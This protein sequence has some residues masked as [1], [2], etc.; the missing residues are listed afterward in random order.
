MADQG[1]G[2]SKLRL[3]GA[4]VLLVE[5]ATI[6]AMWAQST[7]EAAGAVV[8]GPATRVSQALQLATT[9]RFDLGLLDID[10]NGELVWPV[11]DALMQ[12]GIPFV[13]TT[14]YEGA[15]SIPERLSS[16]QTLGKPYR[17][18]QLVMTARQLLAR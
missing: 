9:E 13:F 17:D 8:L 12:R 4:V 18:D 10:L 16:V 5:D 2:Q 3:E 15:F 7:L 11:A 1:A 14:G 6:I